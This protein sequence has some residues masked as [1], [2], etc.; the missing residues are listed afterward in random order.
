MT[1]SLL[2]L[3]NNSGQ[4]VHVHT[5]HQ[6]VKFTTS[7]A[8]SDALCL[9]RQLIISL[10]MCHGGV[11]TGWLKALPQRLLQMHPMCTVSWRM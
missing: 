10:V 8:I 9:G 1:P 6:A 3:R 5:Y 4:V 11:N 7:Q 2:L